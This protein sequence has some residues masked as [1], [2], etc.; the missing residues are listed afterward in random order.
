MP[1]KPVAWP[2]DGFVLVE[3]DTDPE[4]ARYK[5][6][7]TFPG[8]G[9]SS[10]V[11]GFRHRRRRIGVKAA[12]LSTSETP[13]FNGIFPYPVLHCFRRRTPGTFRAAPLTWKGERGVGLGNSGDGIAKD[14]GKLRRF[15]RRPPAC[16]TNRAK[17]VFF[18]AVRQPGSVE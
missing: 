8:Y 7:A 5:V 6:V 4:A 14:A 10:K 17:R 12:G 9:L 16:L 11:P 2:V 18:R 13:E 1:P 15:R 3:S